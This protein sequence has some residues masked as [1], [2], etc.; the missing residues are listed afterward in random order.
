MT[1]AYWFLAFAG[2][3]S[4]PTLVSSLS[5]RRPPPLLIIPIFLCGLLTSELTWFFLGL[6][7]LIA[8]LFMAAG[9][10]ESSAGVLV[11]LLLGFS[12]L[13]MWR[14]GGGWPR[15]GVQLANVA[16]K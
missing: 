6:Q 11:L 13:G 14:G 10:L 1:V 12:W 4:L 15:H 16:V 5:L 8:C 3:S 2:F 9:V 7:L